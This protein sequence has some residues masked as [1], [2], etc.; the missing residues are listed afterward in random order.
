VLVTKCEVSFVNSKFYIK[1]GADPGG[2]GDRTLKTFEGNFFHHDFV[3]FGL[4]LSQQCCE[5]YFSYSNEQVMR[6]DY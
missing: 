6:L 4:F 1:P 5:V 3:Q 2:G